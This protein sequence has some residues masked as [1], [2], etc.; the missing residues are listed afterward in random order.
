M[1]YLYSITFC[2]TCKEKVFSLHFILDTYIVCDHSRNVIH[3]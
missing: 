1:S 3:F 2:Q